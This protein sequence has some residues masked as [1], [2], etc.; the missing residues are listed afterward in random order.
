[1]EK[2]DPGFNPIRYRCDRDGGEIPPGC[3]NIKKRP[4]IEMFADCFAGKNAFSDVDGINE[5]SGN[6][7][8]MEWKPGPVDLSAAQRIMY[9]R[10]TVGRRFSVICIAGDAETMEVTHCASFVNGKWKAWE[11]SSFEDVKKRIKGWHDW[12]K[13]HPRIGAG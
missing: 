1:M 4:K 6:A 9:S 8:L 13:K 11:P 2:H 3:F 5:T 7:L 10:I 12:A